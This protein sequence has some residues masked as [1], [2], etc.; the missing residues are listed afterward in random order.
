MATIASLNVRIGATF[1]DLEKG[2]KG[3][4]RSLQRSGRKLSQI[5]SDITLT[6]GAPLALLGGAAI[7]TAGDFEA[8]KL[9]LEAQIG[10]AAKATEELEKLRIAALAPGLGF[11]Q[12]VKGSVQLQA[13]GFSAER[14][15]ETIV[16]FGNG[17]ALAGKGAQELD[18]VLLALTQISAKGVVSAEEINQIAERLP[19]IRTLMQAA[20]GTASTEALQKLGVTSD[21]FIDSITKEL[22]KLPKATGGIKNSIENATDAVKQFLASV[23]TEINDAL[24]L[25]DVAES[26]ARGLQSAAKA[27]SNLSDSTKQWVIGLAAGLAALGPLLATIGALKQASALFVGG[28]NTIVGGLKSVTAGAFAAAR[29]FQALSLAQR[30]FFLGAVVLA[31]TA[32]A[33]AYYNYSQSVQTVTATQK[34]LNSVTDTAL[35]NTIEQRLEVERLAKTVT[36]ENKTYDQKRAALD[37]LAQISPEYFGNLDKT[38]I[39]TEAV[40]AATQRY[41]AA[42]IQ[43]AKI[44]AAK[45]ELVEYER[46]LLKVAKNSDPSVFQLFLNAITSGGNA[47]AI[48]AANAATYT[49]NLVG[50]KRALEEG[51]DALSGLLE[52]LVTAEEQAPK[53]APGPTPEQIGEAK[54]LTQEYAKALQSIAAVSAKGDVLGADVIGEQATEIENQ[55]ERLLEVGFKP[56]S[57][58]IDSLRDK[59]RALKSEIGQSPAIAPL[60]PLPT[61]GPQPVVSISGIG[62]VNKDLA[63]HV[64]RVID[65]QVIS[66]TVAQSGKDILKG[67]QDGVI[68]F[69]QAWQQTVDLIE[70]SGTAIQKLGVTVGQAFA[71]AFDSGAQ[72]IKGFAVA[73]ASAAAKIIKNQIQLG[74]AAAVSKALTNVPFPFNLAAGAVAGAGAAALFGAIISKIGVPA[75]AAGGVISGPT[76]AL[77]G[78]YPGASTNPE[79]VTPER[80]LRNIFREEQ[81]GGAQELYSVIRG[82]DL[83]LVSDRARNKRNRV[84]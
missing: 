25:G 83:L 28:L 10:S 72:S 36:D 35:D 23:G 18:G 8:L 37:K 79:I 6:I 81:G 77:I 17:L 44:Q 29:A 68:G 52:G 53:K 50:N 73:F 63:E 19:Q 15:R 31:V 66:K 45:E 75:L 46:Q 9:A 48:A 43:T 62:Q 82:D 64:K 51:R 22:Q 49:K 13:V 76:M 54:R 59:L 57:K 11:E 55:I 33:T 41:V 70:S 14:A 32:L 58:E 40:T 30:A 84:G 3:A 20:F 80:L 21:K 42:L 78:E 47:T 69:G 74:V 71:S 34:A 4:E 38:K 56:Y 60:Q 5:G 2:L 16:A 12:A 26:L 7:K 39:S 24:N 67:L 61:Q 1:A 27:F 65:A